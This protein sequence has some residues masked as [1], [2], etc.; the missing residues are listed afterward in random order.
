MSIDAHCVRVRSASTA[1]DLNYISDAIQWWQKIATWLVQGHI[2]ILD[3]LFAADCKPVS[4]GILRLDV[5]TCGEEG[6]WNAPA[7]GLVV[8][9]R[10]NNGRMRR[11]DH[12]STCFVPL[13]PINL[14][15][16]SPL[17]KRFLFFETRKVLIT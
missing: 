5:M 6:Q 16:D 7:A 17:R 10:N 8:I 1:V 4:Q 11:N 15:S 2:C 14:L 9:C 12:F 3:T 13:D